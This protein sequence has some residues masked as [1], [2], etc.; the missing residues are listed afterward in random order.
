MDAND[1]SFKKQRKFTK[2]RAEFIV[3]AKVPRDYKNKRKHDNV[4]YYKESFKLT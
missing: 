4:K 3:W 2:H 1:Q